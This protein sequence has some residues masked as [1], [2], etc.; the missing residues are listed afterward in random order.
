MECDVTQRI[1][2]SYS[3]SSPAP[4]CSQYRTSRSALTASSCDISICLLARRRQSIYTY[5]QYLP[6][7][8][9]I[10]IIIDRAAVYRQTD[11][12]HPTTFVKA[13]AHSPIYRRHTAS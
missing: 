4:P 12:L 9:V 8:I 1:T 6:T 10:I 11:A 2:A 3:S 13:I 7:I 5:H